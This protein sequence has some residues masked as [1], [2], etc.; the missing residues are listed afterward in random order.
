MPKVPTRRDSGTTPA[1]RLGAA[2]HEALHHLEVTLDLVG[3]YSALYDEL[4][5]PT[6]DGT[7]MVGPRVLEDATGL[8]L[9]GDLLSEAGEAITERLCVGSKGLTVDVYRAQVDLYTPE[10]IAAGVA[11]CRPASLPGILAELAIVDPA[12]H[13]R[14]VAVIRAIVDRQP[15]PCTVEGCSWAAPAGDSPGWSTHVD[16]VHPIGG[17]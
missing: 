12:A 15:I 13:Q 17:S 9:L 8:T 11:A 1:E 6:E 3:T 4:I 14:I 16:S 2:L 10:V 7:D 5:E